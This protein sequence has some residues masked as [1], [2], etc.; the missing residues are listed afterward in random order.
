M[1]YRNER[2]AQ[3]GIRTHGYEGFLKYLRRLHSSNKEVS[4]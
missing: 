4:E 2:W 3:A 1:T